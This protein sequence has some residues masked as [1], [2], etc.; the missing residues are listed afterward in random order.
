MPP[1][2]KSASTSLADCLPLA[3]PMGG[4][5]EERLRL[6]LSAATPIAIERFRSIFSSACLAWRRG[7]RRQRERRKRKREKKR[8]E[9]KKRR[10][11]RE[12]REERG[13]REARREKRGEEKTKS[14]RI[15][16]QISID[17]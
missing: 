6:T 1:H 14:R 12:K 17:I 15:I 13:E 11:R 8:E 9:R 3:E 10:E 4:L 16:Y 7:Q 5:V 2:T